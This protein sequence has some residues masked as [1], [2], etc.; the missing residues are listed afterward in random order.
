[1]R[2]AL[3]L[4]V[5]GIA[6]TGWHC[7][8]QI[9][10]L[11]PLYPRTVIATDG[12]AR[13]VIVRPADPAY[14]PAVESLQESIRESTG[15]EV[16]D[17]VPHELVAPD[18]DLTLD[19]LDAS[20]LIALGNVNCN[21]L[22]T[23][24]WGD[25]YVYAD[26]I[27]PGMGGYVIRTVHD[28]F[29]NG[30][31]VLVLAGS[32]VAGTQ[33]AV[34]EFCERYV[35]QA[36]LVLEEPVVDVEIVPATQDF[37][38]PP[39]TTHRQPQLQDAAYWRQ[40]L[41]ERG[42]ADDEGNIIA[43][44]EGT[45]STVTGAIGAMAECLQ[46]TGDRD[47]LPMM[48]EVLHTNRHLLETVEER[49]SMVG[50]SSGDIEGWD[51]VEEYPI[52]T[53]EDR[54][55][56]TNTFYTDAK[57]GHEERSVHR[58]V[59]EGY[60]Q[61]LDENHATHSATESFGDWH[62]F[63]KYYDL[64]EGDYWMD[65]V[66]ATF[67][68]Q[69]STHQ[70]LED[71]STYLTICP[72]DTMD[73]AFA[74]RDLKYLEFGI[75]RGHAEYISQCSVNNLGLNTGFGDGGGL[76]IPGAYQAIAKAAWYYRDP[77][78]SWIYRRLLP[79]ATSLRNWQHAIPHDLTV[80]PRRPDHWLGMTVF[81][82][83]KQTLSK[84]EGSK[85][86][87]ADPRE[88]I[89]PEYFNKIVFR[90]G[91]SP[92]DQYLLFDGAGKWSSQGEPYGPSG[93]KHNDVNTII[94]FTDRGRVWLVD[95][96][97]NVRDIKDH[98]G[99]F[100]T[101]DGRASYPEHEATLLDFAEAGDRALCRALYEGFSNT[102]WERTIFWQRGD[103]FLVLDR[104]MAQEEGHFIIRCSW[105]GL[106]QPEIREQSLY[107]RQGDDVCEVRSDG[108]AY[109]DMDTIDLP[110]DEQWEKYTGAEAVTRI[111]QQDKSHRM[112][113]GEETTFTN[114]L[115]TAGSAADLE[116]TGVVH[117]SPTA[118]IVEMP[119]RRVLCGVGDLPGM[120]ADAGSWMVSDDSALLAGVTRLGPEEQPLLSS[121]TP[122]IVAFGPDGSPRVQVAETA[123]ITLADGRQ[124]SLDAGWHHLP[125]R[126][127]AG[128]RQTVCDSALPAAEQL[129]AAY[130]P[131]A[132]GDGIEAPAL[133]TARRELGIPTAKVIARDLNGD[134]VQEMVAV[135]EQGATA[136]SAD[137][138]TLWHFGTEMPCRAL[139]IGDLDGDGT[140]EV[141]VGCDDHNL[142]MLDA[143]GSRLWQFE[144][145]PTKGATLPG[146]PAVDFVDIVDLEGDGD[147]EVVVGANWTH[148]LDAGGEI[149]WEHYLRLSRGRICGDFTCGNVVDIDG[150][151][152]QEVAAL[153]IDSYPKAVIYNH[154]GQG[155]VPE[156]WT[157]IAGKGP[158]GL[159]IPR[160][161]AL[162]VAR[163]AKG[164]SPILVAGTESHIFMRWCGEP[165]PGE[166]AFHRRGSYAAL[167]SYVPEGEE[168]AWVYA[169]TDMG[170]VIAYHEDETR[171]D[172][173]LDAGGWT[174]IVGRKVMSLW[175]GDLDGDGD[176][177]VL[178]GT[179]D[180]ALHLLDAAS[181]D[182]VGKTE[183]TGSAV[184]GFAVTPDG[185]AAVHADGLLEFPK[186]N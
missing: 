117:V 142:Y 47:L 74:S 31:N 136:M 60:V 175:A 26:S 102:D 119:D 122:V 162:E 160:P 153:Y 37:I 144:A 84:G 61:V 108:G 81:P 54:L 90:E 57:V 23:V 161:Q 8:A 4:T 73:Y 76:L 124:M 83:F 9:T 46:W 154:E 93:H 86:F 107:L 139:D 165:A 13:A 3:W 18:W 167:V 101:R 17:V 129:A 128:L 53:D 51:V 82:I 132:A 148:C 180:G 78:L 38:P 173:R 30:M 45:L 157:Y 171:E 91:W 24:L 104:A 178:A 168:E 126:L 79:Q 7:A 163:M 11:K 120:A 64:P 68:G 43:A 33:R 112:E 29:A 179:T 40:A 94:N 166:V 59:K 19:D 49:L 21:R 70:I 149:L 146:P 12:E 143:D 15:A 109:L 1:M 152:D 56:I 2:H 110:M 186:A 134:G 20:T 106:G 116:E 159:N 69:C 95:H 97:Y 118:A 170:A 85:Q 181:G 164:R 44:E 169:G 115:H 67:D 58:L 113:A 36:N 114:L 14:L 72:D 41:Q 183:P 158:Y 42:L 92:E 32:D 103:W 71:C 156:G 174:Q 100:I 25:G 5:I 87:I 96:I 151:G 10:E 99:L 65:V 150:D 88:S 89:G 145:K 48:R 177:E 39:E 66:Q 6:V 34:D 16:G 147:G 28:P 176:G 131:A 111:F 182:L 52:W 185:V 123:S 135:G 127:T 184:V 130:D 63:Q 22:L 138:E 35:Q 155:I 125:G 55:L 75:A 141:A 98:S 172:E 140:P 133:E 80:E 137:G 27:Y 121:E 50:G 105:R 77:Y 62:Y